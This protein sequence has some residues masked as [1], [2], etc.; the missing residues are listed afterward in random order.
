MLECTRFFDQ[1]ERRSAVVPEGALRLP[2]TRSDSISTRKEVFY[3]YAFCMWD[4]WLKET[5]RERCRCD[6]GNQRQAGKFGEGHLIRCPVALFGDAQGFVHAERCPLRLSI[7]HC[8]L[9]CCCESVLHL[10]DVEQAVLYL[11]LMACPGAR[12]RRP[13]HDDDGFFLPVYVVD[14]DLEFREFARILCNEVAWG[15]GAAG[16][17]S[18]A[19]RFLS[20]RD[21]HPMR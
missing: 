2:E 8:I 9:E 4:K 19:F 3:S 15:G 18:P 20:C 10:D 13:C 11:F 1:N 17:S 14:V 5:A 6:K 7:D 21:P 12:A 16:W